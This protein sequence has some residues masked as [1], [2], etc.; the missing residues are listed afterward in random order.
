[1]TKSWLHR[2]KIPTLYKE[3]EYQYY[4]HRDAKLLYWQNYWDAQNYFI[5]VMKSRFG[6]LDFRLHSQI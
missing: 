4:Q 1:M 2:G 3:G 6:Q 5:T